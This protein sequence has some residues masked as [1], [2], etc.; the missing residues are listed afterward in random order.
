MKLLLG[1]THHR[2]ALPLSQVERVILR[3]G[4]ASVPEQPPWLAG[5]LAMGEAN[6][7]VLDMSALFGGPPLPVE[8]YDPIVLCRAAEQRLGLLFRKVERVIEVEPTALRP[9]TEQD[10]F[11]GVAAGILENGRD[12]LPVLVPKLLLARH[13]QE[14]LR[15]WEGLRT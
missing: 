10:S 7:P 4:L 1:A 14:R 3:P 6:L 9:L 13:Q 5:F 15:H 2:L 12:W 8:L 11:Q